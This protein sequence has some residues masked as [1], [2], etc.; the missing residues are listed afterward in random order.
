MSPKKVDSFFKAKMLPK[1]ASIS[2]PAITTAHYAVG[3]EWKP[4]V[5]F[6]ARLTRD[7]FIDF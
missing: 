6:C 4:L 5:L 1:P 2:K 7:R 3:D